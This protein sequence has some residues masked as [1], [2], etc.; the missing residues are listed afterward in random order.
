MINA[1]AELVAPSQEKHA[2]EAVAVLT[3]TC[4]PVI[5]TKKLE[6]EMMRYEEEKRRYDLEKEGKRR[7]SIEGEEKERREEEAKERH[8]LEIM[9]R[10]EEI[11]L[12]KQEAR[13]REIEARRRD[14]KNRRAAARE[15][16]DR[17]KMKLQLQELNFLA[18]QCET[19]H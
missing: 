16:R 11:E 15:E 10:Q 1:W 7:H 13:D 4:D 8:R 2:A 9:M 3:K 14:E 18:M 17:A 5:E 19:Q 12:R 6:F